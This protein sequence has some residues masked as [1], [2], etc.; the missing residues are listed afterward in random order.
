MHI[1]Y[2]LDIQCDKQRD[3]SSQLNFKNHGWPKCCTETTVIE[4]HH[5]ISHF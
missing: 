3:Y 5:R 1:K 4:R 2:T